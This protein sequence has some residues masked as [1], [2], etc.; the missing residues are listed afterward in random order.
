MG[1]AQGAWYLEPGLSVL[2]GSVDPQGTPSCCRGIAIA[3][4]SQAQRRP[5]MR[6][7]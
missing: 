7:S 2:L 5:L 3:A 6:S 4:A 1:D